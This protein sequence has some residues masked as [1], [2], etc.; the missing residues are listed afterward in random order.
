MRKEDTFERP[1]RAEQV[2]VGNL[3]PPERHTRINPKRRI[4]Q[5]LGAVRRLSVNRER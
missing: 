3:P 4:R 1:D 2:R 5:R